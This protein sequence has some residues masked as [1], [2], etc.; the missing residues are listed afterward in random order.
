MRTDVLRTTRG[1]GVF[2]MADVVLLAEMALRGRFRQV[3]EPLFLRRYHEQRS[4]AAGPTS[5][6]RSRGTT[7]H[8][9]L[10]L[11]CRRPGSPPSS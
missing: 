8:A 1:I 4:I 10:D 5:S 9:G 6:S 3:P 11:P 7:P 2:P